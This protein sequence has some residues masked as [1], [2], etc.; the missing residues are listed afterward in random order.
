MYISK[1]NVVLEE[2][3]PLQQNKQHQKRFPPLYGQLPMTE[4]LGRAE[5]LDQSFTTVGRLNKPKPPDGQKPQSH[6]ARSFTKFLS[7]NDNGSV[8]QEKNDTIMG[9]DDGKLHATMSWRDTYH[10]S[11]VARNQIPSQ[12][13]EP[14]VFSEYDLTQQ[15]P[16][17]QSVLN[18][19]FPS[20]GNPTLGLPRS[21]VPNEPELERYSH[22]VG[23]SIPDHMVA[24]ISDMLVKGT[25]KNLPKQLT[26]QFRGVLKELD[27]VRHAC[28]TL[29]ETMF[30]ICMYSAPISNHFARSLFWRPLKCRKLTNK[31]LIAWGARIC[32]GAR[33]TRGL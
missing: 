1:S 30:H 25:H 28:S 23:T 3:L 21:V 15:D 17:C 26:E 22:L 32:R 29:S 18:I 12:I 6:I 9:K 19:T 8:K 2:K 5:M 16:L 10:P 11:G 24:P 14:E 20:N 31:C 7:S 27:E 13:G 4:R 33:N